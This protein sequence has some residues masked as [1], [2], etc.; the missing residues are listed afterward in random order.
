M[1]EPDVA[2]PE[3]L[4]PASLHLA[5]DLAARMPD[6]LAEARTIANTVTAGWHGRRRAG[7]GETFWQFRSF[8]AGEPA[9]RI[10][11]RRSARDEHLYVREKEWE[12]AHTVWLWADRSRSMGFRSKLSETP[13]IERAAV[14][15]LALADL[16]GRSG[17]RV[18]I[19]GL[20]LPVADRRIAEQ[21]TNALIHDDKLA[22]EP[23][24][25]QVRRFSDVILFGDFLDPFSDVSAFL[26]R[27]AETGATV[28]LVQILDPV[29]ETFPFSGRVEFR[30]PESGLKLV[31]G[32]AEAWGEGYRTR[33]AAHRDS[34]RE[35]CRRLD[36]T[37]ILHHTDRPANE[38]LLLLHN[39][40]GGLPLG[41]RAMADTGSSGGASYGGSGL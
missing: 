30:D 18:G 39:R 9:K 16:L 21:L 35:I 31:S 41:Q 33:L 23:Q 27:L 12:A 24:L 5:K 29:E 6:L 15:L 26:D 8:G 22:T 10:D 20:T 28:H 1:A 13:K 40:L 3:D 2:A 19:P 34:I 25:T 17:E 4:I 36:W 37:F 7:P 32:R 11:W 38:P 14:L